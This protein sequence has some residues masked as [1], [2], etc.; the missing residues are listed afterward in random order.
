M[1]K[2]QQE[3]QWRHPLGI[4]Q[5]ALD[6]WAKEKVKHDTKDTLP[7]KPYDELSPEKRKEKIEFFKKSI[8]PELEAYFNKRKN[9]IHEAAIKLRNQQAAVPRSQREKNQEIRNGEVKAKGVTAKRL[10]QLKSEIKKLKESIRVVQNLNPSHQLLILKTLGDG[11]EQLLKTAYNLRKIGNERYNF[12][13]QLT[14]A[15]D[16]EYQYLIQSGFTHYEFLDAKNKAKEII[17][18]IEGTIIVSDIREQILELNQYI[19]D[20]FGT[21]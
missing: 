21:E 8:I 15:Q 11:I 16:K 10:N 4:S 1:Q 13:G 3:N 19:N 7:S 2:Q 9:V 12:R 17:K 20:N 14:Q 6:P 5:V 18:L